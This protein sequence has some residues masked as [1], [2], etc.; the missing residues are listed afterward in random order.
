MILETTGAAYEITEN[1]LPGILDALS[2]DPLHELESPGNRGIE[3]FRKFNGPALVIPAAHS[4]V[5]ASPLQTV[6]VMRAI[7]TKSPSLAVATAMHHFSVA[8][9]FTL[10]E[11]LQ[12]SGFEWAMLEAIASQRM[13]VSRRSP[14]AARD[15]A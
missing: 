1:L 6:A 10:A 15:K 2:D 4:G 3:I 5:G 12:A 13:L 7:A 11:S 9:L 8:T 14:R